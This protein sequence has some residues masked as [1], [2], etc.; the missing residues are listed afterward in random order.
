MNHPL[1]LRPARHG[2]LRLALRIARRDSVIHRGRSALIIVLIAIPIIGM[3][4]LTTIE[5]SNQPTLQEVARNELGH[6]EARLSVVE[7]SSTPVTQ[8][9]I[10][11]GNW[12][13]GGDVPR[14]N[15]APTA[16]PS[17]FLPAGTTILSLRDLSIIAKTASG[18]GSIAA[19]E[20]E[21][22]DRAF[23]G[24]FAVL[25]GRAPANATEVMATPAALKRLGK[26]SG[27]SV[28]LTQPRSGTF[29]IVGTMRDLTLPAGTTQI[30]ALPGALDRIP[31]TK[32]IQ[33]TSFYLPSYQLSWTDVQALNT[34]G[35]T[36]LSSEV[37]RDPPPETANW[38]ES[39]GVSAALN[40]FLIVVP[41][42]AFSLFEVGLLAGAAFMVG[43]KQQERS[44]ATLASVGGD[45]QMLARVVSSAGIVLGLAGGALGAGVGIAGAW[46]YLETTSDGS[47]TAFPGF[48]LN[49]LVLGAVILFAVLAGWAAALIPARRAS[50]IDVVAAL[51]GSARPLAP[52]RRAPVLAIVLAVVGVALTIVGTVLLVGRSTTGG[53]NPFD[54]LA[55]T[56]IIVGPITLQIAAMVIAPTILRAVARGLAALGTAARLGARD[57]ARNASR[58]VP[59]IGA[60][61][62][63]IFV[64]SFLMTYLAAAQASQTQEYEYQT[65]PGLV[66]FNYALAAPTI[67]QHR[68]FA[69]ALRS[70]LHTTAVLQLDSARETS[71]A[72]GH[73]SVKAVPQLNPA[74]RC[75][76]L[77]AG[78][79]AVKPGSLSIVSPD[80]QGPQY[81]TSP[82]NSAHIWV[83]T[84]SEIAVA[85]G[86]PLTA[87]SRA[88]LDGG[89][90]V[91]FYPQYVR[92]GSVT[93]HWKAFTSSSDRPGDGTLGRTVKTKSLP[94]V[95]QL[96]PHAVDYDMVILPSTA[97]QIGLDYAPS[98]VI[99]KVTSQPTDAQID[100]VNAAR[101]AIEGK[102][103]DFGYYYET[104]PSTFAGTA[105]W[106][107][108]LLCSI[109]AIGAA[110]V[111]IGLAR[112]E[113]RRDEVVLGSLGAPPRLRRA[114]GFWSAGVLTGVGSISGVLLGCIPAIAV[115]ESLVQPGGRAA[116]PFDV[117]W[118]PL[119]LAA[120]GLP[121]ALAIGSWLTSGRT[122]IRYNHRTSIE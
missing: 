111:A 89:E 94:A 86:T 27:Q 10:D 57:T 33:G 65:A 17:A 5:S 75:T 22:W 66:R 101:A 98:Q 18:I 34:H 67:A 85:I 108:L 23:R 12:R 100:A 96:P 79:M 39:G 47:L 6:N 114:F 88:A 69:A 19:T 31:P 107:L 106:S 120:L 40:G 29:M 54:S 113:S 26:A 14:A 32:D 99:A 2:S 45:R 20:G 35:I 51:R 80:C 21:P 76:Q 38:G 112:S 81:L 118:A 46:V 42:V 77:P 53:V 4:A 24:R 71:T 90:A 36:A 78:P 1:E 64:A 109:I 116:V 43:T 52:S 62:S 7:N 25:S 91:A 8:D 44:L 115:S 55:M 48:H 74:A 92:H 28:T 121:L 9:P 13:A 16:L 15:A 63:T 58:S 72:A 56:L 102:S 103:E 70:T 73:K 68:Q 117:P 59:V 87:A 3:S 82:L 60:I 50:R 83:A 30:F 61:M 105:Q 49:P 93:I 97:R 11:P 84:A 110:S 37:L 104:G 95:L 41:F 122:R 119:L